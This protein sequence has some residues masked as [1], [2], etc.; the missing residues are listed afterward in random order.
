M[1]IDQ[2]WL[3]LK[4]NFAR[5]LGIYCEDDEEELWRRQ[6]F[7]NQFYNCDMADLGH[8][9]IRPRLGKDNLL[10]VITREGKLGFRPYYYRV[11]EEALDLGAKLITFDTIADIFGGDENN[12][13]D[14]RQFGQVAMGGLARAT[15]A[16]V[17][18]LGRPSL[19]GQT[20][21]RS[22][23]TE[24][25]GVFRA[26]WHITKPDKDDDTGERELIRNR[27]HLR[28]LGQAPPLRCAGRTGCLSR[29]TTRRCSGGAERTC[30]C[31]CSISAA[32]TASNCRKARRRA[33]GET[34]RRCSPPCRRAS[35][36]VT[37]MP[38]RPARSRSAERDRAVS[39]AH[40]AAVA[41][42]AAVVEARQVQ[43]P[44]Y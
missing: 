32:A 38:N 18:L 11:R 19:S 41:A 3:G 43:L 25:G 26:G 34:H 21:G 5:S 28:H 30:S 27:G 1:A 24:W 15:G 6:Y 10:P 44:R 40:R 39:V 13:S 29:T 23:S 8:M 37:A 17:L 22:G 20:E 12:R 7:I 42:A 36:R 9:Q 14:V 2:P 16:A 35:A 33:A 31:G 4:T